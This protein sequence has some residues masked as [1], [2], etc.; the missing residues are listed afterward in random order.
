MG[1]STKNRGMDPRVRRT[2]NRIQDAFIALVIEKGYQ[3]LTIQEIVY[4]ADVNRTTFYRQF[5]DKE[6]LLQVV[7]ENMVED[8]FTEIDS[9]TH[10]AH[11]EMLYL[12][13]AQLA[14]LFNRALDYQDVFNTM[15]D[16]EGTPL[17][18]SMFVKQFE[19][20][21]YERIEKSGFDIESSSFPI[22]LVVSFISNSYIAVLHWWLSHP[23]EYSAEFVA[24]KVMQIMVEGVDSAF[25]L[26]WQLDDMRDAG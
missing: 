8:M 15:L 16:E 20:I 25:G 11:G 1:N 7:I 21:L 6:D 19:R 5:R 18:R 12:R 23:N 4:K 3:K 14:N 13:T 24:E 17:F 22:S 2:L 26:E 9:P 10:I